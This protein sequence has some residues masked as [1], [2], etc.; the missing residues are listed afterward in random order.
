MSEDKRS[1]IG[2]NIDINQVEFYIDLIS[3]ERKNYYYVVGTKIEYGQ[4]TKVTLSHAYYE[5]AF[6][7]IFYFDIPEEYKCKHLGVPIQ[8][9]LL[10]QLQFL[11]KSN[12][13]IFTVRDLIENGTQIEYLDI[14]ELHGRAKQPSNK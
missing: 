5:D 4:L 12:R 8:N 6:S 1:A 14:T 13:A 10:N 3:D 11:K 9:R 2:A 7:E